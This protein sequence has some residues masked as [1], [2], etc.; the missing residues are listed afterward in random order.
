MRSIKVSFVIPHKGREEM[1]LRTLRSIQR[2]DYDLDNIEVLL[3]SQNREHSEVLTGLLEQLQ[4]QL[5]SGAGLTTISAVRNLGVS[6]ARGDYLA[7]LD[8][9]VELSPNWLVEMLSLLERRP[10]TVLASAFQKNGPDA[11]PLE[12]IR[13]ALSNA[14]LDCAVSFLPGRNLLLSRKIFDKVGGFPEHLVTCEDYYF[15]ER[16]S[17]YGELYYSTGA[18]YVHVG[19]D[20]E[21]VPMFYK[22]IWRGQS[23]IASIKGRNIPFREWFSFIVPAAMLMLFLVCIL[24]VLTGF[25]LI[26][27]VALLLA[28]VPL[29]AYSF[30]LKRIVGNEV[31][32][33]EVVTFYIYYF[34][35][36]A[37]GTIKGIFNEIKTD[38][39]R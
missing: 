5:I 39:H 21:L 9:D 10:N 28:C 12:R 32:F 15:T 36:R 37:I 11:P 7:F 23:N 22:E 19:E 24:S 6:F 17:Q 18:S 34:P 8:A 13:T 14:V 4:A 1:L 27:I 30:R 26:G 31:S 3:V 38:S 33:Y 25:W 16:V 35:A 29:L 20:K 2:Q